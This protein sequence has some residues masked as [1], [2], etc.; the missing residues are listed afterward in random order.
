MSK[1]LL[2]S[3]VALSAIALV[4]ATTAALAA[5]DASTYKELDQFMSVFERVR[6][7]YVDTVDDKT[8]IK[9]AIDGMLTSLDPHSSYLDARDFQQLRTQTEGNYGGLGLSVTLEDGV[10][11]VIAPTEDTPAARAGIKAGDYITHIDKKLIYGGTLDEAVDQMR[12]APGAPITVTV[13]RV[14][15]EKPFDVTM[16]REIIELKPV[17]W[18]IRDRVGVININ[19]FSKATGENVLAAIAAIDKA[20]GGRPL[21]YIVDMRSNPG[22][23]LDQAIEVSD[24]FLD[25]GEVVSQRGR[26]KGDIERYY[27]KPGDAA[28]GLPMIVLVDSGSASASEIVAGALQDHRRAIVM[29]ERSFGK[30]SVQTLLPLT[31]QSALRLTTARYFTPSGKS[32][33]EGGIRPDIA[34]PQLSDPDYKERPRF[35]E[36]DLQRHLVNE[37]VA[38]DDV[39]EDDGAKPDPRFTDTAE[40]LKKRGITD[41]Q[42]HYAVQTIARLSRAGGAPAAAGGGAR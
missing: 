3:A 12:G 19:T 36:A 10:V 18:E 24:A 42:L 23:L 31:E 21:G 25:Q 37:A 22:G 28:H 27:A 2:R 11:K 40:S 20:T 33:Q 6:G 38:K 39:L 13:V 16:R 7:E 17:K 35:R 34:V 5:V 29:G 15:Q 9:G 30:G 8:L 4:P 32:V 26:R 14:G 41:F 1:T